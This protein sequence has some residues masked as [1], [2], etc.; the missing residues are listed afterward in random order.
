LRISRAGAGEPAA[1]CW[2][3]LRIVQEVVVVVLLLLLVQEVVLL[4]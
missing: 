3:L 2:V 1:L 4:L